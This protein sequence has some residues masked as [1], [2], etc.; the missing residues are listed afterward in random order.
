MTDKCDCTI[1]YTEEPYIEQCTECLEVIV[2]DNKV[3]EL[4][5][6]YGHS[7]APGDMEDRMLIDKLLELYPYEDNCL[8]CGKPFSKCQCE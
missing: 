6:L 8:V 4:V 7:V 2:R 1:R 5:R 3:S